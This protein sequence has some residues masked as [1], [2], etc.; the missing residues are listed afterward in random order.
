MIAWP[1]SPNDHA[2]GYEPD[3]DCPPPPALPSDQG[4]AYV[5]IGE[6]AALLRETRGSMLVCAGLL[7]GLAVGGGVAAGLADREPLPGAA[8]VISFGLM[9]VF[10]LCWLTAATRLLLAGRPV[11]NRLSELRWVTGAPLDPAAAWL[12]LPP[13]GA[14]AEGWSWT[15]AHLLLGAARLARCR[16]QFADTWTYV[17]AACYVVWMVVISLR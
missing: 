7:S 6:M 11:L 2:D 8:G 16:V 13:V 14:H 9:C 15:R 4:S 5:A 3:H 17:A 1:A 12:T 10:V